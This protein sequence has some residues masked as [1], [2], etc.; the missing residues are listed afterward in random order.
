MPFASTVAYKTMP[1]FEQ[2]RLTDQ[3]KLNKVPGCWLILE[4]QGEVLQEAMQNLEGLC[5]HWG[6]VLEDPGLIT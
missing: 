2:E 6:W 4:A 1:P 5:E 3:D